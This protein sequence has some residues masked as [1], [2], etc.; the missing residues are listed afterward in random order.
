MF[1]HSGRVRTEGKV[2]AIIEVM[3]G[4]HSELT[5]RENINIYGN[6][7]GLSRKQVAARF[8]EIVAFAEIE[9][10]ID[11]QVKFYSSG[12][13]VRLG[14]SVAAFLEPSILIVDEVLA[15]GDQS[16]Q[17][18]CLDRMR[19]VIQGGTTLLLVSH[20][21]ASVGATASRGIWLRDGVMMADGPVD[22]VLGGYRRAI[23]RQAE[24]NADVKG[25][26]RVADISAEGVDGRPVTV[27]TNCRVH[28]GLE[29]DASRSVMLFL[30][31]S[32]GAATP[33][34]VVRHL[35]TLEEGR[36]KLEIELDHLPL[37]PRNYF[38]WFSAY[39][40]DTKVE[41]TAWQ[42]IG[43][44]IVSGNLRLP[45]VPRAIVRLSPIFVGARWSKRP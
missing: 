43:P 40:K 34:F 26:V 10:A 4:I 38:W 21:L 28:L 45:P 5:G 39:E 16:F 2:G 30:G 8:D 36:T 44:L 32:E 1:P 22:E 20:D 27:A 31:V 19:H 29:A 25:L 9:D 23:E 13:K 18:K 33:I 11:R 17:Q 6:L 7:L 37:P 3:S 14:F 42:P 41:L 35:T 12:M 24:E 15:V